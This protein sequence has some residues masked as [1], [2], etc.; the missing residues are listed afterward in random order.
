MEKEIWRDIPGYEG[1][2]K[3]SSLGSVYA[4]E[5]FVNGK[6]GSIVKRQG[7]FIK[8]YIGVK[9]TLSVMLSN[10]NK[11][12]HHYV[13]TLVALAF[14]GE[15][16]KGYQVCHADGN[17]KNNRLKNLRYDTQSQNHIDCYRQTGSSG[18]AKLNIENVLEIR[19]L[20]ATGNFYQREL[21]S[22][23]KVDIRQISRVVRRETFAWLND[24]GTIN[25]SK[26]QIK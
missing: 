26:T 1:L 2:Y 5:K 12:K 10:N 14:I 15:K 22:V 24:D 20:Y 25:E 6:N 9:G 19:R 18:R 17:P 4:M 7:K 13:H 21:A 3:I 11:R 16:P 23:Y 8:P